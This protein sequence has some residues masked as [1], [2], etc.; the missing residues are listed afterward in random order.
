MFLGLSNDTNI[1]NTILYFYDLNA[2]ANYKLGENDRLFVSGYF[3]KDNFGFGDQF[4]F[5]W[6]NVTGT[7]RWNHIY[8]KK[9][10]AN[11]SV[12]YSDYDY[13]IKI[14]VADQEIEI[15]SA[16]RDIN[17]KEDF[18]YFANDRKQDPLWSQ[19]DL[20]Y[21]YSGENRG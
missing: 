17:I 13:K 5:D 15:G 1:K 21:I 8:N 2:K 11:T 14:A 20:S 16:I 10:F 9:L 18:D 6:G 7:M 4:G 19:C 3:G 12:I